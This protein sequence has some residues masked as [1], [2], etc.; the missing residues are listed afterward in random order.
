MPRIAIVHVHDPRVR[1]GVRA[2]TVVRITSVAEW[3]G[4]PVDLLAA[5]GPLPP[6]AART[7]RVLVV[8][9]AAGREGGVLAAGAIDVAEI[10]ADSVLPLPATLADTARQI[11][12]IVV[13]PDSSLSLLFEPSTV[14]ASDDSVVGEEICQS[15]S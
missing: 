8:R 5:L 10:E 2:Q 14:I 3:R 15:R 9:N 4:Q 1:W 12:A 11:P 6:R 7:A 13:S